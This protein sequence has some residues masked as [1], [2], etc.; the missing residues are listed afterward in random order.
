MQSKLPFP[1]IQS[2]DRTQYD[3]SR[4][5]EFEAESSAPGV[6]TRTGARTDIS[7]RLPYSTRSNSVVFGSGSVD[8]N[9]PVNPDDFDIDT[10]IPSLGKWDVASLIINKTVG[11]GIFTAPPLVLMYTQN[12]VGAILLWLLGVLFSGLR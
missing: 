1:T 11:A 10:T 6:P 9:A 8:E 2:P 3:Q 5:V 12:K 4:N 7:S